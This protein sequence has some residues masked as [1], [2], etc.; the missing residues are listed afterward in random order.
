MIYGRMTDNEID[1]LVQALVRPCG[2]VFGLTKQEKEDIINW[3]KRP[4]AFLQAAER[5]VKLK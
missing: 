5:K 2:G 4:S 3:L 1:L